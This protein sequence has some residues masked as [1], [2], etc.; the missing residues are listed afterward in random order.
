VLG[1]PALRHAAARVEGR[2][3]SPSWDGVFL[4]GTAAVSLA[5]LYLLATNT[6]DALRGNEQ[7]HIPRVANPP[8]QW[9]WLPVVPGL[10]IAA[11]PLLP[12]PSWAAIG[13]ALCAA[14]ALAYTLFAAQWG[15]GDNL[16]A[17]IINEP[18]GFHRAAGRITDVHDV[19]ANYTTYLVQFELGSHVRSH[20]PG[21][22]LLFEWLNDLMAA[23]PGLQAVTL[24]WGKTFVSG[25]P[26]LLGAG[27]P[28]YLMAGAVAAIPLIIGLGR[29]AALPVAAITRTLGEPA[30]PA[31]LLFLVLPTTLVHIP[32]LDTVYPLLT[33]L[34]V[35]TGLAAVEHR[36][37]ALAALSGAAYA[38]SLVFSASLAVIAIPIGIYAIFRLRWAAL[39][40]GLLFAAGWAAVWLVLWLAASLNMITVMQFMAEHQ[41]EFE[42]QRSYWLWFRWKWYDFAMFCG[43]PVAALCLKFLI[44]S[45]QRWR[46][47]RPLK[48]DYFFAG[49]L[50]MMVVLWITPAA[51]AEA[52]RLW[53]PLMCFAVLFAAAALPRLRGALS[54]V[55]LLEIAQVLVINRYLEVINSG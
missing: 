13:T 38:L 46:A 26:M 42:A 11:L 30:L 47:R 24:D 17:K 33:A 1:Q 14:G 55:L 2:R 15:G 16:M 52:G 25:L 23:Q 19:L 44:E 18:T 9:W 53:A 45:A 37:W 5:Y 40:P 39:R 29:V 41:R 51:L 22:L 8:N 28:G 32:L 27:N 48:L 54:L 4:A 3:W 34:V 20:P 10:L 36:S 35:L 31:T 43:I 7:W 21:N 49:W 6:V 12:L 50:A